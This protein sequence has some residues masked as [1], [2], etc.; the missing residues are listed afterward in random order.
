M[1]LW[2]QKEVS[3]ESHTAKAETHHL[4]RFLP[5]DSF[6]FFKQTTVRRQTSHLKQLMPRTQ[7]KSFEKKSKLDFG[8]TRSFAKRDICARLSSEIV[9]GWL[10]NG[11]EP[12][13]NE[14]NMSLYSSF[15]AH[16]KA[17]CKGNKTYPAY[18]SGLCCMCSKLPVF[19]RR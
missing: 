2:G 16:V 4:S 3:C 11:Y 6:D 12:F 5:I 8:K 13:G 7:S 15:A 1:C 18:G 10:G 14:Y 17:S 9:L 19:L